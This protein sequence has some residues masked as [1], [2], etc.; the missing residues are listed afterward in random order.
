MA[1]GRRVLLCAD[2][3]TIVMVVSAVR[4]LCVQAHLLPIDS[5]SASL[6]CRRRSL[7]DTHR[8]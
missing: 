4:I 1:A 8:P 7:H 2:R 3:I 6:S 5:V